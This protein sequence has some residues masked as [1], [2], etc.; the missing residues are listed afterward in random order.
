MLRKAEITRGD[1]ETDFGMSEQL[2]SLSCFRLAI[3]QLA[4]VFLRV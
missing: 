1:L 4:Q 3:E 2:L